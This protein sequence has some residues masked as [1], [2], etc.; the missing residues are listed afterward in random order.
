[1]NDITPKAGLRRQESATTG[2][3]HLVAADAAML[4]YDDLS[5]GD[6]ELVRQCVLDTLGVAIAGIDEDVTRIVRDFCQ[7]E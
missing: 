3:T 6:R 2:A 5:N 7:R 1:M 4:R